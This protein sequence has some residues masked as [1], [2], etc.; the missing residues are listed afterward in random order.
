MKKQPAGQG[1]A[2][3]GHEMVLL[4]WTLSSSCT[5]W[6]HLLSRGASTGWGSGGDARGAGLALSGH[7]SPVGALSKQRRSWG[8]CL[9]LRFPTSQES[10][11]EERCPQPGP[12]RCTHPGRLCGSSRV[13]RRWDPAWGG[14]EPAAFGKGLVRGS[15]LGTGWW[16]LP[17]A[18]R[19]VRA[20]R[21]RQRR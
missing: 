5:A 11:Y 19:G 13:Q 21:R 4:I 6:A 2:G 20:W 7:L 14:R 16:Q 9:P 18:G 15:A 12:A 17:V 3:C 1:Q 10:R 8:R